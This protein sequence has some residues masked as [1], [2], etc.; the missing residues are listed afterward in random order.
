VIPADI[1]APG[2]AGM[3]GDRG[4]S[5]LRVGQSPVHV[6]RHDQRHPVVRWQVNNTFDGVVG[7]ATLVVGGIPKGTDPFRLSNPLLARRQALGD[8][9]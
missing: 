8:D 2:F 6:L 7:D 9:R 1:E 3:M 5:E 4:R